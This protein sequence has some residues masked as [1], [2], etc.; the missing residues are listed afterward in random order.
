MNHARIAELLQPFLALNTNSAA[1]SL[2]LDRL[3]TY[4]DL[5]LHWNARM[6]LTAVREPDAIVA[7]H[8]GESLFA[9]KHLLSR[10]AANPPIHLIDIGSGPGFPGLP[11]KLYSPST[12]TALIESN[13]KK[14]T[15]LREVVRALNI[16]G[17][18]VIP[19]RAEDAEVPSAP[20]RTV[21]T[22]RAVERFDTIFPTA[23]KMMKD[24]G[25][26]AL[27][28]GQSQ[29]ETTRDPSLKWSTPTSIPQSQSRILLIG[30]RADASISLVPEE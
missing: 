4:L 22:L 5:L 10:D 1:D 2:L 20:G 28:I 25:T 17:I 14:A 21:V 29:Y 11:M 27:M 15:F 3:A 13:Q 16:S 19:T 8:F 7:R 23:I 26:M 30:Q 18:E 6:N 24:D 9:A 12:P